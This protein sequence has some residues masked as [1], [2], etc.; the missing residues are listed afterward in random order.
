MA[1]EVADIGNFGSFADIAFDFDNILLDSMDKADFHIH[2]ALDVFHTNRLS[3][4]V[5]FHDVHIRDAHNHDV[6]ILGQNHNFLVNCSATA[7]TG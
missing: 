7:D 6:R 4:D 3:N 1:V 2:D 5:H